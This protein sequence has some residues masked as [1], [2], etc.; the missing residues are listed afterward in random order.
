[1]NRANL[2]A[3]VVI[4]VVVL[5]FAL[6]SCGGGSGA[7]TA[8]PDTGGPSQAPTDPG[9]NPPGNINIYDNGGVPPEIS[10]VDQYDGRPSPFKPPVISGPRD[11]EVAE[12]EFGSSILV[13][14]QNSSGLGT[15]VL[16]NFEAGQKAVLVTTNLDPFY[17]NFTVGSSKGLGF[18]LPNS[19][20]YFTAD[21]LQKVTSSTDS[22]PAPE[23]FDV[24]AT[25]YKGIKFGPDEK[26]DPSILGE[27]ELEYAR[28]TGY[29]DQVTEVTRRPSTL[30]KGVVRTF[31]AVEATIQMPPIDD[32]TATQPPE[33]PLQ[34]PWI[35]QFQDG[36][37]IGVGAHCY[38]FLSTEI[39]NGYPDGT[40]FTHQRIQSLIQE[41][42]S[43][44]FP[45]TQ[46]AFG[47]VRTYNEETIY[48]APDRSI[49]L[50]P[51]DFDD[52][53]NLIGFE[54]PRRDDQIEKDNRIIIAILN[55]VAPGGGGFFISPQNR[56]QEDP[57]QSSPYQDAPEI[58]WDA[59]STIY[60]DPANFPDDSDDW[61]GAFSVLAHEFQHKLHADNSVSNSTWL[62]EGFSMLSIYL[63]GY[64]I[65][66]NN[67][68][69]F[70][71]NQLEEF[72]ANPEVNAMYNDVSIDQNQ[73]T[74][75]ATWFLY[76]LY[77]LEHYGPGTIRYFYTTPGNILDRLQQ[78]TG[79]TP[80]FTFEKWILANYIDGLDVPPMNDD[81]TLDEYIE[82]VP[83]GDPRFR[84]AT[85]DM[86]GRIGET[87]DVLPGVNVHRFPRTPEYYPVDSPPQIVKPWCAQYVLFENGN[88]GDLRIFVDADA[89]YRTFVLPVH[90]DPATTETKIDTD[91]FI[92]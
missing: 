38:V 91:V 40:K 67:V 11:D 87:S 18:Q 76:M 52:D 84:Y 55:G 26:L 8:P 83:L 20:Y 1:M 25:P 66:K 35:Y 68:I 4:C 85:F 41:F 47:P 2:S 46:A 32:P 77:V 39:N 22:A 70:F 12:E 44:I 6:A 29:L 88:G 82:R 80:R 75:Y 14:P 92:P 64:S 78:A 34:W 7:P 31:T 79:E 89:N 36:R 71:R 13:L 61:S 23:V 65:E 27:R 48:F 60:L 15:L 3:L 30:S 5:T 42:D 58:N 63:N 73:S 19:T 57:D 43:K 24:S 51:D 81:E 56:P 49:R 50:T 74:L 72:M 33:E 10:G 62:N 28:Q 69:G 86:K 54:E 53:G 21:N 16:K 17:L 45:V 37:L 59:F 9:T 90:Y